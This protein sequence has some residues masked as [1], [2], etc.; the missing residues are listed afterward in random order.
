MSEFNLLAII[1]PTASGKT[2]LAAHLAKHLSGEVISMDSRQ[3]YRKLDI[4]SGKDLAEYQIDQV[5]IPYH[6]IDC[7]DIGH[8]YN[9]FEFQNDFYHVLNKIWGKDR[10]PVACGGS[11]MY[12]EAVIKGYQLLNV[13]ENKNLRKTLHD[14]DHNIL[15]ERL[16]AYK[17]LH[18]TTDTTDRDRLLRAIEIADYQANVSSKTIP[19]PPIK[20]RIFGIHFSREELKSR[21]T[22]RLKSRLNSGMIDEVQG[23]LN[24]QIEPKQLKFYGLEYKY[25]TQYLIG[26]LNY[27][28][29]YQKLNSAIHA[30]A[31]RQMTWFR[32]MERQGNKIHWIDGQLP[33]SRKLD[34]I[35]RHQDL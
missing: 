17:S 35:L 2:T 19:R 8:E 33:L 23:L 29:M 20:S 9:V 32:K 34:I 7:V 6:L 26:E 3:V 25:I 18:N 15:I 11:G 10:L 16:K 1:G 24:D 27:N 12:V 31:K 22:Q 21:I 5:H 30:F 14:E 28:D 4:G 13:P